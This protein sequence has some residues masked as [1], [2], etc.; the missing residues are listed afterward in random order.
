M[1]R[2]ERYTPGEWAQRENSPLEII[3]GIDGEA[4]HICVVEDNPCAMFDATMLAA[5]P[6][7]LESLKELVY[8]CQNGVQYAD[9]N[10]LDL[11]EYISAIRYAGATPLGESRAVS[12][13]EA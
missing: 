7:L 8:R 12:G 6:R 13:V 5:A 10:K 3:A 4:T 9:G 2:T 11:T 1:V